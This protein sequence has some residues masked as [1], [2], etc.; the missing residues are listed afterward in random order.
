VVGNPKLPEVAEP[1]ARIHEDA[2]TQPFPT[3]KR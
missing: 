2:D 1:G 3:G